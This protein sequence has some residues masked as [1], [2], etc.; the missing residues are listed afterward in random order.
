MTRYLL[1]PID[2]FKLGRKL[3]NLLFYLNFKSQLADFTEKCLCRPDHLKNR[4]IWLLYLF[5]TVA[6]LGSED[7]WGMVFM[8]LL[9][10][11]KF[12]VVTTGGWAMVVAFIIS[13]LMKT[14]FVIPR[15][16]G[17]SKE[18]VYDWSFPSLHTLAC[19]SVHLTWYWTTG[20][21]HPFVLLAF[22]GFSRIYLRCH[23]I[24]DVLTGYALGYLAAKIAALTYLW[25][26][27]C[28]VFVYIAAFAVIYVIRPKADPTDSSLTDIAGGGMFVKG[29]A[30][31]CA[32]LGWYPDFFL[33]KELY[34]LEKQDRVM[35]LGISIPFIFV[36]SYLFEKVVRNLLKKWFLFT[37]TTTYSS[38]YIRRKRRRE[39]KLKQKNYT[40]DMNIPPV[41]LN[42]S[43]D[44]LK[45]HELSGYAHE[46]IGFD[47]DLYMRVIWGL[48]MGVACPLI[49]KSMPNIIKFVYSSF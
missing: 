19:T 46:D 23:H 31:G 11:D 24:I 17:V 29:M 10:F 5:K 33:W 14:T 32:V 37:G 9:A 27:N 4:H 6:F 48:G 22:I 30:F 45:L 40:Q 15:P 26:V 36:L 47:S 44:R 41:E 16:I 42:F 38:S 2:N 1:A 39:N 12:S 20:Y 28:T 7:G 18:K 3:R 25:Y 21:D 13:N 34:K 43:L 49:I 8:V 35:A